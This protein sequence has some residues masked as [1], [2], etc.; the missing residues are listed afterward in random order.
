MPCHLKTWQGNI[1]PKTC[2][3]LHTYSL[4][5]YAQAL[6][7]SSYKQKNPTNNNIGRVSF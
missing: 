7:R 6:A 2:K 1:E 4:R 5:S 3:C